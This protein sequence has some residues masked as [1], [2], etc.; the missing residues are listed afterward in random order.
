M[1]VGPD[2]TKVVSKK[3]GLLRIALMK[4]QITPVLSTQP[5]HAQGCAPH[6]DATNL[7]G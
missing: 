3:G 5:T 6:A 4:V 7:P 2:G 1:R